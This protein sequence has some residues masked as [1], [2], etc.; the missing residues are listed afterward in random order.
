MEA[1]QIRRS[2][3]DGEWG[4]EDDVGFMSVNEFF[5]AIGTLPAEV[6]NELQQV[7]TVQSE[8]FT[9]QATG[10][11]GNVS[12]TVVALLQRNG[13]EITI[14]SWRAQPAAAIPAT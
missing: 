13:A 9:V 4:T 14:I 1:V 10:I 8:Y 12:E 6:Q 11:V 7:L 3:D 5:A 2:G